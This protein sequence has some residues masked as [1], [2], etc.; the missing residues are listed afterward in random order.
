VCHFSTPGRIPE[1]SRSGGPADII[2]IMTGKGIVVDVHVRALVGIE[3]LRTDVP[4]HPPV[5]ASNQARRSP[6]YH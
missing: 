2:E 5:G 6:G 3:N 4:T 1:V